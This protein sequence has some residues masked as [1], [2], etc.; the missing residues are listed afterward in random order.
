[1]AT[2]PNG[3]FHEVDVNDLFFSTTDSKGVIEQANHVFVDIARTPRENLI[4]APH[5]VIRHPDMPGGAFRIVWE[6]I[7]AREPVSAYVLNLAG[8][9]S[10]YWAFATITPLDKGYISVRARPCD[11]KTVKLVAEIYARVREVERK[12][13]AEG[14][15]PARAACA[16]QDAILNELRALGY[17][18]YAAFMH[19]CVP[20]EL[21]ARSKAGAKIPARENADGFQRVL[22]HTATDIEGRIAKLAEELGSADE[23]AVD[24]DQ[25]VSATLDSL[26]ALEQAIHAARAVSDAHEDDAPVV[27]NAAPALE[28]QCRKVA[29]TMRGVLGHVDLM[30]VLR[31]KLRFSTC[32]AQMQAETVCRFAVATIDGKE[33]AATTASANDTLVRSLTGSV[34]AMRASLT[35]DREKVGELTEEIEKAEAAL[36]LTGM[37]LGRWRTLIEKFG[38]ADQMADALPLLDRSL[39]KLSDNLSGL[40]GSAERFNSTVVAFDADALEQRLNEIGSQNAAIA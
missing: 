25:R 27:A 26:G 38:L 5:N 39:D 14:G 18:N 28:E 37:I 22:L 35:L 33:D 24:L 19:D 29:D 15:S 1:M 31:H 11:G 4:G 40:H 21:S 7:G 17:D 3:K 6:T 12:V 34:E 2:V 20:A 16:G 23:L 36:R 30:C 10:A 9:G 8:D 32:L 13:M